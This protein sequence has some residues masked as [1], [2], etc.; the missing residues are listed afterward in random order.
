MNAKYKHLATAIALLSLGVTAPSPYSRALSNAESKRI[1][2]TTTVAAV[3]DDVNRIQHN[4]YSI[5][6]RLDVMQ[7]QLLV[8][9]HQL[10]RIQISAEEKID[11]SPLPE[12][13]N[14]TLLTPKILPSSIALSIDVPV[15]RD[16]GN[17]NDPANNDVVNTGSASAITTV[18]LPESILQNIADS[19]AVESAA[20]ASDGQEFAPTPMDEALA[21]NDRDLDDMRAGFLTAD[22][23]QITFGIERAIYING[24]LVTFTSLNLTNIGQLVSTIQGGSSSTKLMNMAP[25]N[26]IQSV[27]PVPL[28]GHD[29]PAPTASVGSIQS[30]PPV[31]T[32]STSTAT[33]ASVGAIAS[34]SAATSAPQTTGSANAGSVS[35]NLSRP[36]VQTINTGSSGLAVIQ[37]GG[38]N[39]F[40]A[41]SV[42]SG[43]IGTIVQNTLNNQKIQNFTVINA[44][45]NS[46]DVLR[47]N[48]LQSTINN[49]VANSLNR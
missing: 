46:M 13:K 18:P 28:A 14:L 17:P 42:D 12:W 45:V 37:S 22:G 32:A 19:Q 21:M 44:T 7:A 29:A 16:V 27:I 4:Q 26:D 47:A 41:G 34:S 49:A 36:Q 31:S 25:S 1:A 33:P 8:L 40:N 48:N 10:R 30:A 23:L 24:E 11:S 2:L 3:A 9:E 38:G 35:Q 15:Q 20:D 43:A 6:Q 5:K 39:T